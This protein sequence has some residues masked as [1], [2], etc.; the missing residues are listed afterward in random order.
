M[1]KIAFVWYW[2]GASK[3]YYNWR[4]GLRAAIEEIDKKHLVGWYMDKTMPDIEEDHDIILLWGDSNC[5]AI[6]QLYKYR[7]KKGIFLTTNPTNPDNLRQFDAVF[8]ESDVVFEE[9]RRLGLKGVKAFG[10]DTDFFKPKKTEKDIEYF[11]PATFSP[12]KKQS[13]IA[14]LGSKL[15]C[16]GTVQPD[17]EDEL[18]ACKDSGVRLE[19]GYFPAEKIKQYYNRAQ[20]VVIP[21]VHG[22]ERTVLEAMSMNILPEILH[23]DIN[24]KAYSFI[25]EY[26]VEKEINPKLTPRRFV[27]NN[28]SHKHYAKTVIKSLL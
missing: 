24:K 20:H 27:L 9:V 16:V 10:T 3:T 22:S 11:Y 6:H 17:G 26:F 21:A 4:D 18:Q 14:Y 19:I 15:L 23:P 2:E 25:E 28:Y 7:A 1:K 12:W 8:C 13:E 5:E